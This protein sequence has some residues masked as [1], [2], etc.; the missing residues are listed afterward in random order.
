MSDKQRGLLLRMVGG[1]WAAV[2]GL[3]RLVVNVVFLLLLAAFLA[4]LFSGA[5]ESVVDDSALLLRPAGQLV[6]Q[7][8]IGD[9][10]GLLS[11]GPSPTQTPL[12]DLLE[13]IDA[14]AGDERIRGIVI[15]T[16]ALDGAGAA[17]LQEVAEAIARFRTAAPGKPVV[18]W[19][20]RFTQG[21]F[22]LASQADEVYMA[23]DG[24][25]LV[26]GFSSYP[27]YYKGLFD[28][29]DVRINVFRVGSY[30]SAVEPFTRETMSAQ[31]RSATLRLLSDL[32]RQWREGVAER[33]KISAD[34]LDAVVNDY[35]QR[36]AAVAGDAARL[37]LEAGLVDGLLTPD[38]WREMQK[39]RFGRL[40]GERDEPRRTTLS[41]YL[42]GIRDGIELPQDKIAV[43]AVQGTI[44][45]GEQ[46]PGVAG[47][48][49]VA[50]M[51]ARVRQDDAVKAL[52]LRVDS[53]GGS[54]FASERIRREVD[55][56]RQ[57]GKTVVAS[58]SSV[59]AS[60][61]YWVAMAADEIWASPS[62]VTGSIGIFGMFPDLSGL[63]ARGGLSVDGV[64]TSPIAGGLD[65]RRPLSEDMSLALK[66]SIEN[67]Y[68]RFVG[69]VAGARGMDAAAVEKVAQG[70][71]WSGGQALERGLIDHLGGLH[72]AIAAAAGRA[73]LT[74]FRVDWVEPQL[75]ARD[76]ILERLLHADEA[77][78]PPPRSG[79][80]AQVMGGIAA[81]FAALAAWNDPGHAY[82]HCLCASP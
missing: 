68:R 63:L 2:N 39:K 33:R 67:G 62:T 49:T 26:Q 36:L 42:A 45:D 55:L 28:K 54:V 19:G 6:E 8:S 13:A 50:R 1:L 72:E 27:T 15:E 41:A 64:G 56:V 12:R 58:M 3:R 25:V 30:K 51:L 65:P 80:L 60:G 71:V 48:E 79:A 10:L 61:G 16:D 4:L 75:N 57:A 17:K 24:F 78:A 32:W 14:A 23:P 34:E 47:G 40:D 69:L 74:H 9:P 37:A 29:L 31:D 38:Q 77:L 44:V 46:P 11:R 53:P 5:P 35:P 7:V 22:Y 81:D 66:S 21:Q 59:A 73:G 43:V 52:V 70:Q 18:A 76:R 82:A 20:S